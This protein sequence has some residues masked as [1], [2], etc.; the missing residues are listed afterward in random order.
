MAANC[1][2]MKI[3][4]KMFPLNALRFTRLILL[5]IVDL[6]RSW[7][8][9]IDAHISWIRCCRKHNIRHLEIQHENIENN[10]LTM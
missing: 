9:I 4:F 5:L 6:D 2:S 3:R 8:K 7:T 1:N 10:I